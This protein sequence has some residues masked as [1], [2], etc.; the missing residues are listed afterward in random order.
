MATRL[1]GPILRGHARR[2]GTARRPSGSRQRHR[3][4]R[5]VLPV[6][7]FA[8]AT[9]SPTND[10]SFAAQ[11]AGRSRGASQG[12][13]GSRR[14]AGCGRRKGKRASPETE[15][16]PIAGTRAGRW[17]ARSFTPRRRREESARE[18]RS[19]GREPGSVSK[20]L[21]RTNFSN[22][23]PARAEAHPRGEWPHNRESDRPD[24]ADEPFARAR[25]KA[26]SSSTRAMRILAIF[27]Y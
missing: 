23:R 7:A 13:R 19:S 4:L 1:A 15:L 12:R 14:V 2:Q 20:T 22:T 24:F 6:R 10:L 16:S 25:C 3:S 17:R 26:R 8:S 9:I 21:R 5:E 18:I 11:P 27:H